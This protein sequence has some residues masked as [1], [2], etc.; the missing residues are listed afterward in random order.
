MDYVKKKRYNWGDNSKNG[1]HKH[2]CNT[3]H[4]LIKQLVVELPNKNKNTSLRSNV[5]EEKRHV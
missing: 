3:E 1:K 5:V 4:R 2:T